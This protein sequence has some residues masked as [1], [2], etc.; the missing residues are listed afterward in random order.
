[1]K[2]AY[3]DMIKLLIVDDEKII[4]ETIASLIDWKKLGISLIG[5]AENGIDALSII[6]DES[7]DIVMTDIR[8]PGLSGL[9]LIRQ[10][11][12]L[13]N[14]TK[15][16][17]LSG[18]EEFEYAKEAMRHGIRHYLLKPCNES[19]IIDAI[20]AVKEELHSFPC[21]DN[22]SSDYFRQGIMFNIISDALGQKRYSIRDIYEDYS[23]FFN[24]RGVNYTIYYIYY[25]EHRL[26]QTAVT[27]LENLLRQEEADLTFFYI[28][29]ENTLVIFFDSTSYKGYR[30]DHVIRNMDFSVSG[31]T[32]VCRYQEYPSLAELLDSLLP[33]IMRYRTIYFR[34]FGSIVSLENSDSIICQAGSVSSKIIDYVKE[35][36]T[37]P[38]L[39]LKMI[40]EEVLYMNPDYVSKRFQKETG[41]KFSQYLTR[42]R[43]ETAKKILSGQ[44]TPNIQQA[45]EQS[46]YGN[47]PLYFSQLFRKYT[48]VT[49]SRYYKNTHT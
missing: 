24:F 32:P 14:T 18:Y 15:F 34:M 41:E 43:M 11:R 31:V 4:R 42:L 23:S 44:D 47:N 19:Q 49:P 48:S 16:I 26:L 10:I 22:L 20:C 45:A 2:G 3:I 35:H 1:M 8:M 27:A 21:P 6:L 40:S 12:E 38:G 36:L 25:L 7:P 33:R 5:C 13:N 37:D 39:S 29:V 9:D 17:I 30:L 28:Y 46:G